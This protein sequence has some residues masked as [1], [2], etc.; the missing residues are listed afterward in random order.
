M[1]ALAARLCTGAANLSDRIGQRYFAHAG[2]GEVQ[3]V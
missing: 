3:R 1:A 2:S